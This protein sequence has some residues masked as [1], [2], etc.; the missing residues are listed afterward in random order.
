MPMN[1]EQYKAFFYTVKYG[2]ISKASEQLYITQPAVSRSIKQLEESLKCALFF[3][4]SKGVKLTP[5]GEILCKYIEQAFSFIE[6]GEN[7]LR[8]VHNLVVGEVRIGVSDT[9]CKY[10]LIPYLKLFKTLHPGI[11]VH[12]ICPTTP[13][14]ISLLKA[15]KID[16]G[17]INLPYKDDQ[18]EFQNILEVQDCFVAGE[19]YARLSK[20]MQPL[21]KIV[22]QPLLLLEKSSNSRIFID[23][24]FKTNSV[25]TEPDFELG[26]IDLLIQFAKYDFGIACVIRNFIEDELEKGRLYE[27]KPIEKIPSRHIGVTWLKNVPLSSAAKVLISNLDYLETSEI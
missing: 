1:L 11:K 18:L 9:I 10:Y 4:T 14:I 3:R 8:D 27:I 2:N 17:I 26:N 20:Q 15:G 23:E 24:Y 16:F 21:K 7:K 22:K 12:V 5:E 13:G 19:K 6:A 25:S